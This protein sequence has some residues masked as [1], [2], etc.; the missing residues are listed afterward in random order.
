MIIKIHTMIAVI[1][2]IGIVISWPPTLSA[3]EVLVIVNKSVPADTLDQNAIK[4][5][6]LGKTSKWD[7]NDRIT[8]VI[9][10]GA[11]V[12]E[13]FLEKYIKRTAN[14]FANVWRQN[15]FTGKGK[16]PYKAESMEDLV[17][18][19]SNTKGAIGYASAEV[20]LPANVKILDN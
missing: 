15:M 13:D 10:E 11:D 16:Q 17:H 7:N 19:V 14:Q 8:L 5:I 1:V 2:M 12:H 20:T 18:Y 6:F 9:L 4:N 3:G